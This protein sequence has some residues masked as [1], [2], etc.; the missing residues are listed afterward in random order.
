MHLQFQGIQLCLVDLVDMNTHGAQ[1]H[2]QVE[3]I[4]QKA[5]FK[6]FINLY[7]TFE[8]FP[9]VC[10]CATC[11]QCLLRPGGHWVSCTWGCWWLWAAG[12]VSARAVLRTAELSL[13]A[14]V[15]RFTS[16]WDRSLLVLSAFFVR[17]GSSHFHLWPTSRS[18]WSLVLTRSL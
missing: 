2:M 10:M 8:C 16:A 4:K 7:F 1:T 15:P 3:H 9:A 6:R 18:Q 17:V 12:I 14:P 11:G 5:L 13:Q